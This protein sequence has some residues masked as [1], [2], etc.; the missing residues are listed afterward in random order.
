[1]DLKNIKTVDLYNTLTSIAQLDFSKIEDELTNFFRN[2]EKEKDTAIIDVTDTYFESK[3]SEDKPRRGKEGKV[4]KLKQIALATTMKNGFPLFH[5][6][7]SGNLSDIQIFKDMNLELKKKGLNTVIIDR[8]M[9]SPENIRMILSLKLATI[10][11]IKK[12]AKLIKSYISKIKREEIYTLKN[13]VELINTSVY[14]Q[15]FNYMQGKLIAVYNPSM[16]ILKKEHAFEKGIEK[17]SAYGY[18]LIYSN[19]NYEDKEIVKKYY[20][21]DTV[22]RAFKQLKGILNLRPIRVWLKE[23]VEGHFKIC[24]LAYAILSL[25]N[26]K[27]KK[28]NITANKAL[29]L[30]KRGYKVRL[31]DQK[32]NHEWDLIV[33][34]EP[35]QKEILKKLN[36]VYKKD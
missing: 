31:K 25:M 34:L 4:R 33:P 35:H 2:F 20:E 21:K 27:L 13:R 10:A 32:N 19:T 6:Q 15:S 1:L 26:F 3:I 24:F 5:K 9:T 7:Y 8:G 30:L 23:H 18:S 29:D 28:I 14:I 12:D 17:E 16:E 11:G 36:V 22:E